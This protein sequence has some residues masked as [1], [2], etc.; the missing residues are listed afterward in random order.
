MLAGMDGD[1]LAIIITIIGTGLAGTLALAGL[2]MRTAAR[3]DRRM[4][5]FE[6]A[7]ARHR[8]RFEAATAAHRDR[9]E[10]ATAAHRDRFEDAMTEHRAEMHRL[11]E[12]QSHVEGRLDERGGGAD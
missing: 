4:D 7:M 9:F 5:R 12:R 8:D 10:A 6:D 11:A 1:A 2:L 3:Q